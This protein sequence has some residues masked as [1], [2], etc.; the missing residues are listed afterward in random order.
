V[1]KRTRIIFL[2]LSHIS[3]LA[4]GAAVGG[5][6]VFEAARSSRRFA[7]ELGAAEWYSAQMS[8]ERM[9]GD[10]KAYRSALLDYLR[11]LQS[12]RDRDGITLDDHVI[13]VDTVLTEARLAILADS[14]GN[15]AES[16]LYFAQA[17]EHCPSA[18]KTGCSVERLHEIVARLD[19]KASRAQH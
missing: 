3:A 5:W 9:M 8:V 10:P 6:F 19:G 2:A 17:L 11:A 14:Q 18:W 12:R 1:T 15:E 7:D 13:A 16:K 4:I